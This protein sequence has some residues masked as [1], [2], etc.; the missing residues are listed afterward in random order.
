VIR[1]WLIGRG[2][3]DDV[4]EVP[5]DDGHSRGL[6][7]RYV[8]DRPVASDD[9]GYR[10]RNITVG[11]YIPVKSRNVQSVQVSEVDDILRKILLVC[12]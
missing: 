11:V 12:H 4:Q 7:N 8:F 9:C 10:H 1:Q 5:V 3:F 2:L 6:H